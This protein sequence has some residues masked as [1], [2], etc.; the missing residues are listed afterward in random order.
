M[1][2]SSQ[3]D[4]FC[5]LNVK[6][7]L[8]KWQKLHWK[9]NKWERLQSDFDSVLHK[10][11]DQRFSAGLSRVFNHSLFLV[12]FFFVFFFS[13]FLCSLSASVLQ[14]FPC[15]SYCFL[16]ASLSSSFIFLLPPVNSPHIHPEANKENGFS[17]YLRVKWLYKTFDN[18]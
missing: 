1:N 6:E 2:N 11:L 4:I 8:F 13:P 5:H 3:E 7:I 16:V 15:V 9:I 10:V 12:G 14:R 17:H 18:I